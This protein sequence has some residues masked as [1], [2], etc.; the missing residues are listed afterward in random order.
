MER[1]DP[2]LSIENPCAITSSLDLLPSSGT[3]DFAKWNSRKG[4][5]ASISERA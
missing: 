4:G 3:S 2:I 5:R 1:T